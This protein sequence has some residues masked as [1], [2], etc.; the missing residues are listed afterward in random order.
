VLI[1]HSSLTYCVRVPHSS[2]TWC[3]NLILCPRSRAIRCILRSRRFAVCRRCCP[4]RP[5]LTNVFV[6]RGLR[7][8]TTSK[9]PFIRCSMRGNP[10]ARSHTGL[11]GGRGPPP[12]VSLPAI[13]HGWPLPG[14]EERSLEVR[15]QNLELRSH[16]VRPG[17]IS[18][19]FEVLTSNLCSTCPAAEI[20][21]RWR[22]SHHR[23][24]AVSP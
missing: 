24:P 7:R 4:D 18:S 14:C 17:C 22:A 21:H 11:P 15:T 9:G 6:T 12:V 10:F 5:G 23:P 20:D 8:S 1:P 16:A 2:L 13:H 19:N 3:V